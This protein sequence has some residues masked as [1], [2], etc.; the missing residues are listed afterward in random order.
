MTDEPSKEKG[1]YWKRR[2]RPMCDGDCFNCIHS[3][4]VVPAITIQ[5]EKHYT[6][7]GVKTPYVQEDI[8]KGRGFTR[9]PKRNHRKSPKNN[10]NIP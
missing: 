10:K 8:L 6:S 7:G 5:A 2:R 1:Y 4:C 9:G 3:D